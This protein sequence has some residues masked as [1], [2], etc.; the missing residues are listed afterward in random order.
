MSIWRP[1]EKYKWWK[2]KP[3]KPSGSTG[4]DTGVDTITGAQPGF[5][6]GYGDISNKPSYS[7]SVPSYSPPKVRVPDYAALKGEAAGYAKKQREAQ[8]KALEAQLKNLNILTAQALGMA[9]TGAVGAGMGLE[10]AQSK[11]GL[12]GGIA[13]AEQSNLQ[14]QIAGQLGDIYG[15]KAI[16]QS[17]VQ[18]QIDMLESQEDLWMLGFYE[19]LIGIEGQKSSIRSAAVSAAQAEAAMQQ[20]ALEQQL[21]AQQQQWMQDL[22]NTGDYFDF[23]E[24]FLWGNQAMG[25]GYTPG[26]VYRGQGMKNPFMPD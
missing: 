8:E 14:A 11:Y 15:Q 3:S 20:A 21:K 9:E 13:M 7:P 5:G 23:Y 17:D 25:G 26:G 2:K 19:Q 12:S 16:A 18:A 4:T 10:E 6:P 22:F 1:F 24:K